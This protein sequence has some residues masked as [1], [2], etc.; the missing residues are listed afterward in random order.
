MPICL[1][2]I[3]LLAIAGNGFLSKTLSRI[4]PWVLGRGTRC[5]LAFCGKYFW[6]HS[7]ECL[8]F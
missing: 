8:C 6:V 3:F 4:L 1:A 5:R 7:W 2:D